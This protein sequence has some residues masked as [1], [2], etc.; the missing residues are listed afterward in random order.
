MTV[1]GWQRQLTEMV[2]DLGRR[3]DRLAGGSPT[4]LNEG[5]GD[6]L[7]GRINLNTQGQNR[8][9]SGLQSDLQDG[10]IDLTT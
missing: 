9:M 8:R 7:D 3:V 6:L 10:D 2:Q 5:E 4:E 1:P